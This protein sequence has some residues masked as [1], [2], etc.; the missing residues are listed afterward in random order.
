MRKKCIDATLSQWRI[1]DELRLAVLLRDRVIMTDHHRAIGISVLG[2]PYAKDN[3]TP[4][5]RH[6]RCNQ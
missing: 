1:E 4:S 2:E 3:E 6:R 5:I